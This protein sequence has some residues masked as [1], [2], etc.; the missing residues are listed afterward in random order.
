M[1]GV[2]GFYQ[3]SIEL[4]RKGVVNRVVADELWSLSQQGEGLSYILDL[5]EL[6]QL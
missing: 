1:T 5:G 6:T 4:F 2:Q 3:G